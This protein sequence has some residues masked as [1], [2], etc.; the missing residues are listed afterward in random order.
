MDETPRRIFRP[1]VDFR[2]ETWL[3]ME[4]VLLLVFIFAFGLAVGSF[5]G[6]VSWRVPRGVSVLRP[7]S[8]CPRCEHRLGPADLVPVLSHLLARGRC[9]HCGARVP[10]R[11]SIIEGLAGLGFV[12]AYW[13]AAVR[14]PLD[15]GAGTSGSIGPGSV[16]LEAALSSV[17]WPAFIAA[18]TLYSLMLVMTVIDLE[19][20]LLPD[21][22]NL[23]G[24]A[25]GLGFAVWGA[26]VVTP[27]Q[28]VYGGLLGYAVI[29]V[30]VFLSRGGMGMG[31][32]KFL[33]MI[34]T[35]VGPL[36]VL[37]TLFGASLLGAVIGGILIWLGKHGRKTPIPFGP[38]L[39]IAAV[40]V[41]VYLLLA[42]A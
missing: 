40:G 16:A 36:G 5:L 15:L 8:A 17:H 23:V 4:Q 19:H 10:W 6:A 26:G 31:D 13:L 35:F 38:F 18:A 12:G 32:A 39:A 28:A 11:Y 29:F 21:K 22:I 9:R 14:F 1:G 27:L 24:A 2:N 7:P 20:M 42:A 30:I 33:A 34:G 41:W 37:Y 25:A 3:E